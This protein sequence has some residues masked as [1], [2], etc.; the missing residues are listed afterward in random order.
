MLKNTQRRVEG[1]G[2]DAASRELQAGPAEFHP[3]GVD[4]VIII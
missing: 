1:Q 4:A 2:G 3:K